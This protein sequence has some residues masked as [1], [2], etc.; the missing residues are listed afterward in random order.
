CT[1]GT[2]GVNCEQ[3][4]PEGCRFNSCNAF[5]GVCNKG[6]TTNYVT[7]DCKEKY[8][9]L[10]SPP[11]LESSD[12]NSIKLKIDLN[13]KNIK[14]SNNLKPDYYQVAFKIASNE[15][16][17]QYS[18]MK[19]IDEQESVIEITNLKPGILYTFGAILVS[20]D[21]NYNIEDIKTVDYSTKC[22]IPSDTN[23]NVSLL[24][25]TNYINVTWNKLNYKNEE[26]CKI[27]EYL[28]K[29]I[30][31][32][33]NL[34]QLNYS[35]E[36]KSNNN[37]GY[38]LENLLPGKKYAV[39]ITA[40]TATGQANPSN[41]SYIYTEPYGYIQI[42]NI[43]TELNK[44]SSLIITWDV[45]EN[46]AYSPL[47]FEFK[48]KVNK[49]FSCSTK[50]LTNKWTSIL[51]YNQT[52]KEISDLIPNTQYVI[53]VDPK[54]KGYTYEDYA[55]IIFV[56]T[57]ISKPNLTPVISENNSWYITNQSAYFCWTIN[58]SE[59]S[60]L[61]GFFQGYQIRLKD[62]LKETQVEKSIKENTVTF[63]ELKPDTRYEL[64]VY[65]LT[66][67]GYN[68]E[69]GLL[70]PFK[71]KSKLPVDELIRKSIGIR[72]SFNDTDVI[73]GFIVIVIDENLNSTKQ[74][75]IEPKRCIAWPTF[76]CTTIDNLIPTNQYTIKIKAKSLD[77]PTGGKPENL[78]TTNVGPTYISL[79]WDIPWIHNGVLKSFIVNIEE[80]SS[81]D[82]DKCCESKPDVE[83]PITE[84]L[85]SY[86]C[87]INDLKPGST[88]SIGVLSKTSSYGQ[89]SKIHVTT[90]PYSAASDVEDEQTI[91]IEESTTSAQY[92]DSTAVNMYDDDDR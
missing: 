41:L 45:D 14:G 30:F 10:K 65:V 67:Y 17:F 79:E 23:Y 34:Q 7:P 31:Y 28:V 27:T 85:P 6:C 11:Q 91:Q 4:C 77:Y 20:E 68:L 33:T 86:N 9:W 78:K 54:I 46:Q 88:Y 63:D 50:V 56:K 26:D 55:N 81:K 47:N 40:I 75:I 3:Q 29:L 21:G 32:N 74:I 61:N 70:I 72:W 71:T 59:C 13:L 69:Q 89:T 24:S 5:T 87:T 92:Y 22:L 57:P 35:E 38:I 48:Y 18:E 15:S 49:H 76:Y 39:Q 43:K 80:I 51:V 2:Y 44:H 1:S 19:K 73:D 84:E 58:N 53:K 8:P 25:G 52:K 83:I 82:I 90:L 42:K 36:V 62:V 16:E 37:N 12:F 60:K 66:N 64:Q